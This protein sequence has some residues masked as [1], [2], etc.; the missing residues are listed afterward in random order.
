MLPLKRK[1]RATESIA[2]SHNGL[3]IAMEYYCLQISLVTRM[4]LAQPHMCNGL[5]FMVLLQSTSAPRSLYAKD[6]AQ[7]EH[8]CSALVSF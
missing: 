2:K 8:S 4:F 5:R 3:W 6:P 7:V 1:C